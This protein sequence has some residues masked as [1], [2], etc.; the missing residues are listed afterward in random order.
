[1][2]DDWREAQAAEKAMMELGTRATDLL[3]L[4]MGNPDQWVRKRVFSVLCKIGDPQSIPCFVNALGEPNGRIRRMAVSGIVNIQNKPEELKELLIEAS[5]SDN[6]R[7][8]ANAT[9]VLRIIDET[10][11][12]QVAIKSL[13]DKDWKVRQSGAKALG[14]LGRPEAISAL[15][16]ALDDENIDVAL[17]AAFALSSIGDKGKAI[18]KELLEAD[19]MQKARCAAH[20]LAEVGDISGINLV[21]DAFNDPQWDVWCTPFLLAESGDRKAIEALAMLV[22]KEEM[23]SRALHSIRALSRCKDKIALD[24][25][26]QVI[27]TRHD[28]KFRKA[29]FAAL[30]E[31]GTEDAANIIIEALVSD[32]GNLRQHAGSALIRIGSEILPK[33][34]KLLEQTQGK[35]QQAV[36]SVMKALE[37]TEI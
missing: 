19:N 8:R 7:L 30:R 33:L 20:A 35:Q 10:S 24:M 29:A 28:R 26:K 17:S 11:A 27:Y 32:D 3:I 1:M 21:I 18:L 36:M 9:K 15:K 23:S 13:E 14:K 16:V 12:L 4:A 5:K 22:G 6:P 31:M 34:E 25:L 37:K 2:G